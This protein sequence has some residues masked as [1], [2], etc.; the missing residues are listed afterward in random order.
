[1]ARTE[2]LLSL[3]GK[4]AI[5]P[6]HCLPDRSANRQAS[7]PSAHPPSSLRCTLHPRPRTAAASSASCPLHAGCSIARAPRPLRCS[8]AAA[9]R[10][11]AA[12]SKNPGRVVQRRRRPANHPGRPPTMA[13]NVPAPRDPHQAHQRARRDSRKPN[14]RRRA[15]RPRRYGGARGSWTLAASPQRPGAG[16]ARARPRRGP[17]ASVTGRVRAPASRGPGAG[18]TWGRAKGSATCQDADKNGVSTRDRGC[19]R[20]PAAPVLSH[21]VALGFGASWASI[22]LPLRS[23]VWIQGRARRRAAP[24]AMHVVPSQGSGWIH[25]CGWKWCVECVQRTPRCDWEL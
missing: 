3:R 13:T 12:T 17:A 10:E 4:P 2:L 5:Y 19:T 16:R 22:C 8:R 21:R 14:G 18:R 6:V 20:A 9:R 25:T 24:A 7:V 23:G 15:R 1:M 11:Y